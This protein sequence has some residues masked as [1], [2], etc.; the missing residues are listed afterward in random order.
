MGGYEDLAND[1]CCFFIPIVPGMKALCGTMILVNI[2]NIVSIINVFTWKTHVALK[3]LAGLDLGVALLICYFLFKW[4]LNDN[5]AGRKSLVTGLI[6]NIVQ[7]ICF[8]IIFVVAAASVVYRDDIYAE[9]SDED[10]AKFD[11]LSEDEKRQEALAQAD[12]LGKKV[13]LGV[14]ITA[15]IL[16]TALAVY[17]W[18]E[19]KEYQKL[20]DDV[21]LGDDDYQ[22]VEEEE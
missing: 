19:A 1:K 14:P 4:L 18:S 3:V 9:L 13:A 7:Q 15:L 5:K 11:K 12:K 10:K 2:L 21:N 22:K 8:G 6:F 16:F 20:A 17:F